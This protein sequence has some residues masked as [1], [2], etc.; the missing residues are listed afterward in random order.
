[1]AQNFEPFHVPQQ[2]RK[3]KLRVTTQTNQEQQ[4]PPTPLFS[5]QAPMNPSQ[6]SSFSSLQTLKDMNYQPLTSQGLSL[7]LSFQLDNQRYNAVSV[8]GDYTKQNGEMRSSV[9]P[10]GPFTGYASILTSSRFLKPAQQI[11]DEICGVINCANANFPLD[12]LGESEI[13]RESIAFLSGGVEHQW[14]NSKL[15][16]MLDEH[17]TSLK[18]ALLDKIQFTGRTFADSIVTKEKSPRYGKTERGIGN[19]NPTLNLNFIQHSVWRSHRG[20]PDHAVAVLKT[21]LFEH[22]LHP[23]PTDSE[24]QA[25]AQ[26]TGLSRTQVSNWFINARVRLW[27]PMV[28]EVHMLESQQTQAPSETVNQGAN[29]PSDLPLKKQSR[30]TSHQNTNQTTRSRLLNEL[31]DVSKQRQDP[32]N[33][34][35]NNFSGNYHTAGVSGSKGV[36][37]ALGLPQNNGI[38]LSWPLPMSIPHHVNVEMI[39]MMDSAPATGFELEKQHFGKE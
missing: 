33:I 6:S 34:Y 37:L 10:L 14:K 2:N 5:R 18:N 32:V 24:K 36:S 16:L 20:L 3:N 17:F 4:N 27:K 13:T 29:M 9:V 12:G 39:G 35:G 26:Q 1:M 28:E 15:I 8:S 19:Q 31:P 25:L 7:C 22:F 11:L 30:A 38:D 21:W 23:Y